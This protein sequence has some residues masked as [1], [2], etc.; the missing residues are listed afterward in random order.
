M[1]R[2]L[3]VIENEVRAPNVSGRHSYLFDSTIILRIPLQV[4]VLPLLENDSTRYKEH[5][6][7]IS[8]RLFEV[9]EMKSDSDEIDKEG[10][11]QHGIIPDN[12]LLQFL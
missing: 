10:S 1:S 8:E 12:V 3:L 2:I 11:F 4:H 6:K 7:N 9:P 5:T